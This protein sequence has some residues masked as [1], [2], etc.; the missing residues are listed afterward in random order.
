MFIRTSLAR[1]LSFGFAAG[2]TLYP[3]VLIAPGV[4]LS[5]RLVIHE[6]IH[7][8]QQ[9]ELLL[10]PFYLLYLLEF[11]L[12]YFRY[13]NQYQAYRHIS[14]EKEAYENEHKSSYLHKRPTWNWRH[15]L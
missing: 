2:I 8:R 3:F 15:Y 13:G 10:L 6:K 12:A 4:R 7:L 9:A 1:W 5:R 11:I 14:F